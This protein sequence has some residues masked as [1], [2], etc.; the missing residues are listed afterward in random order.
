MGSSSDFVL[1]DFLAGSIGGV[2]T[3]IGTF[4]SRLGGLSA[5]G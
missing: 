3:E 5:I 4:I 2:L 1:G